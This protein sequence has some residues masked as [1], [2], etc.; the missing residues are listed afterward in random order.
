MADEE[1][2]APNDVGVVVIVGKRASEP[3]KGKGMEAPPGVNFGDMV[4]L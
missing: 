2:D 3:R 1:T 4:T